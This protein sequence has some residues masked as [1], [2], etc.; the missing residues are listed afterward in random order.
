[1][2]RLLLLS[3]I[4][5]NE[6]MESSEYE[7]IL[8]SIKSRKPLSLMND[9]NYHQSAVH[10]HPYRTAGQ[11]RERGGERRI[12]SS[13]VLQCS[14]LTINALQCTDVAT[15]TELL[16]MSFRSLSQHTS[17]NI[18]RGNLILIIELDNIGYESSTDEEAVVVHK[19]LTENECLK[20][21]HEFECIDVSGQSKVW[22]TTAQNSLH[23]AQRTTA[24]D[25][26]AE[27]QLRKI[28]S[29]QYNKLFRHSSSLPVLARCSEWHL[30]S[31]VFGLDAILCVSPQGRHPLTTTS[32]TVWG[33]R[34]NIECASDKKYVG[35]N[36][37]D[38]GVSQ[39]TRKV[40]ETL[41]ETKLSAQTTDVTCG[42][43]VA[44]QLVVMT[45]IFMESTGS[46][47]RAKSAVSETK[48]DDAT[49]TG[50]IRKARGIE[51]R[52]KTQTLCR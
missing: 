28:M 29:C 44:T 19:R 33:Q 46:L 42:L 16:D 18:L 6:E 1:M 32:D 24:S 49:N 23:K 30:S 48:N 31:Q 50:T 47:V 35:L 14:H 10:D 39:Q 15:T 8:L 52:I 51:R 17:L 13:R 45:E 3:S 26:K 4:Q 37:A 9:F 5:K 2:S 20:S 7:F 12:L 11:S 40:I 38:N 34:Y 41:T 27:R 21:K 22:I 25:R 36:A 43:I